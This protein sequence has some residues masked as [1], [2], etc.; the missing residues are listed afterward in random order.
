M[1]EQQ[2]MF[3]VHLEGTSKNSGLPYNFMSLSDGFDTMEFSTE[4]DTELTKDL[5]EK[6]KV[7]VTFKVDPFSERNSFVVVGIEK[8]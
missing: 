2:A 3:K 4:L 8:L 7:N 1:H 6:D 5:Q